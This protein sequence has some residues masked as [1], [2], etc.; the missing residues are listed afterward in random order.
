MIRLLAFAVF[1]ALIGLAEAQK[2]APPAKGSPEESLA[3]IQVEKG[4]SVEVWASEPLLQ[5]PVSF[6]FDEKGAVYVAETN[7]LHTGTPDTRNFMKWLDED[8]A[9]RTV[10]DRVAMYKKHGYGGFEKNDDI[11]RKVWDS[12]GG[13]KADKSSVFSSGYNQPQDGLGAGVLPAKAAST[14]RTSPTC[15]C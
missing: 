9:C 2:K 3:Q 15:T 4:H 1:I 5:N 11:V 12:T 8:L 6:C 7:R 14:T 13:G 10:A